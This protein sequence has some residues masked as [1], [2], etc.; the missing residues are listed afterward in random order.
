AVAE[1]GVV[2]L[3]EDEVASS[4]RSRLDRVIQEEMQRLAEYKARFRVADAPN[5]QERLVLLVDDGLATGSTMEAAAVSLRQRGASKI[6]VAIPVASVEAVA[7]LRTVADDVRA[8]LVDP[9]FDAVGPY[10]EVFPQTTDE[11]VMKLLRTVAA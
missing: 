4:L 6:I 8:I 9:D 3:N 7:R 5:L 2:L 11:E 10:Y 1:G